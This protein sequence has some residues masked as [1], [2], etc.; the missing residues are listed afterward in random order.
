MHAI[1][2][3]SEW[4]QVTLNFE[5]PGQLAFSTNS[6]SLPRLTMFDVN[7]VKILKMDSNAEDRLAGG[8]VI[9]VCCKLL[10]GFPA[11]FRCFMAF[12]KVFDFVDMFSKASSKNN[13]TEFEAS[14]EVAKK[15]INDR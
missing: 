6:K 1:Q 14:L 12:E 10:D 11:N 13:I 7:T 2:I 4:G 5:T 8:I 15:Q 9:T 3:Y